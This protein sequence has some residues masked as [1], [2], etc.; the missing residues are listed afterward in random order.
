MEETSLKINSKDLIS[1]FNILRKL[2]ENEKMRMLDAFW[3]GQIDSKC[4][5]VNVLNNFVN[6]PS[7]VYIFGGWVG[8]LGNLLLQCSQHIEKIRSIDIDPWCENV[9][10]NL[11]QLWLE[12]DWQ[13]KAI[14][15][16]MCEYNYDWNIY[17]DI[18]INTSTEHVTQSIYDNWWDKIPSGSLVVLQGNNFFDCPEHIRCTKNLNEFKRVNHIYNPIFEGTLSNKTYDRYMTIN[19]K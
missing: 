13:F 8:L 15:A 10:D 4:W 5:L 11:N 12:N 3:D 2:S 19:I 14:T 9:A 6:K 18:V 1:W 7:N 16:D 17:P